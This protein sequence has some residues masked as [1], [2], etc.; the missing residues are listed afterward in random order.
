MNRQ[1]MPLPVCTLPVRSSKT[2]VSLQI[3]LQV[4]SRYTSPL[5]PDNPVKTSHI[6]CKKNYE[7]LKYTN[8]SS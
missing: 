4:C 2:M 1:H 7:K 6:R 5:P 3:L 8:G